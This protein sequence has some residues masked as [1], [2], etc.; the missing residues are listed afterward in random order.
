MFEQ[1][2][3]I[4]GNSGVWPY[5]LLIIATAIFFRLVLVAAAKA[6]QAIEGTPLIEVNY[7]AQDE[8]EG[9]PQRREE[10]APEE[11]GDDKE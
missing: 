6:I 1:E 9:E 11:K 4:L 7:P 10:K 3:Q 5:V 8:K 2:L